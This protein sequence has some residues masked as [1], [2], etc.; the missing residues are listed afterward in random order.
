M[1]WCDGMRSSKTTTTGSRKRPLNADSEDELNVL[2]EVAKKGK[3]AKRKKR[4]EERRKELKINTYKFE[5]KHLHPCN[6]G[7]GQK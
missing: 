7:S 1:L 4:Q 6:T 2:K 5:R 3:S